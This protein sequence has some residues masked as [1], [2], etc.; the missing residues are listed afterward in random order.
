MN[1]HSDPAPLDSTK[2]LG[3]TMVLIVILLPALFALAAFAVNIA[4]MESVNTEIQI[5]TDAAARAAGRTYAVTGDPDATLVA[6]QDAVTRN[7]IGS[8]VLP[9]TAGDLEFGVSVRPSAS[10]PYQFTPTGSG[11]SVRV[12]TTTLS[13]GAAPA[14]Q[15]VFPFFGSGFELRP[16]KSA[17]STQGVI[18]ISLVIDMSGSMAYSSTEVA[19]FPPAPSSAPAGWDFG[20]P[21]PPN[22]RWLDMIAAVQ[23]FNNQLI[24]SPQEE[25]LSLVMYDHEGDVYRNLTNDYTQITDRLAEES[26]SFSSGGTNIGTGIYSA[27]WSLISSPQARDYAAKVTVVMTDGVHNYGSNPVSAAGQ[28]ADSGIMV[29][30][31]TFSNEADQALMQQVAAEGGGEHF[32]AVTAAQLQNAF[33]DIA[34]RLPTL[35]TK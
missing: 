28:S 14:I 4:H 6:A 31:V 35:L 8:Y 3:A 32:H 13:S 26:T 16:E 23:V 9:I 18:D 11:N 1:T 27:E 22:A 21:V 15:S 12:T 5:A 29:F 30:T 10:E 24:A 17:I 19:N 7:P 2:R 33:Q 20:D 34:R 25:L